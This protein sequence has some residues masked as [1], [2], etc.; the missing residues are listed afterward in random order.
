MTLIRS[1]RDM[2][3]TLNGLFDDFFNQDESWGTGNVMANRTSLPAVN[4]KESED[5]YNIELAAPGMKK[6]DFNI[7]LEDNVLTISADKKEQETDEDENYTR[8]EFLYTSFLRKFTLPES[9]DGEKI[10]ASYND[11]VLDIYV[12]KKEEAK[13]R[14]PKNIDVS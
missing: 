7:E 11:G 5:S 4:V 9:A 12:P 1:R 8:R 10:K 14:P 6:K 3:P 2:F 13:P